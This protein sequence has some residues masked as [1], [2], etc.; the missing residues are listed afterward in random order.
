M[1]QKQYFLQIKKKIII[2]KV[3]KYLIPRKTTYFVPKKKTIIIPKPVLAPIPTIQSNIIVPTISIVTTG[4]EKY[5][6]DN[7]AGRNRMLSD[8]I[9]K[10]KIY[11]PK[12]IEMKRKNKF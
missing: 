12:D 10:P 8:L 7:F 3:K 9:A 1:R 6:L 2:P 4:M 11:L 5:P